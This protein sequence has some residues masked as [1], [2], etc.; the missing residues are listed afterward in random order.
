MASVT[1][2]AATT[3][4]FSGPMNTLVN[5]LSVTLLAFE[6]MLEPTY[7]GNMPAGR[8]SLP[9]STRMIAKAAMTMMIK[10]TS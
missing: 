2:S 8:C 4:C 1:L 5:L 7:L 6:A 3:C 9:T 10:N